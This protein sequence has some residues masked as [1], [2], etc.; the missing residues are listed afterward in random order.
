MA[1]SGC[2]KYAVIV[3]LPILGL[4]HLSTGNTA[5]SKACWGG[6]SWGGEELDRGRVGPAGGW[7]QQWLPWPDSE[8]LPQAGQ[9]GMELLEYLPAK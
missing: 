4:L 7:S 3:I 2:R 5:G 9:P 6:G 1:C 8:Y